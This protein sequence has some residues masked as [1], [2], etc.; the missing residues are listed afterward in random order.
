MSRGLRKVALFATFA[1]AGTAIWAAA[2]LA[3]SDAL[4]GRITAD[5]SSTVGPYVA[6]AAETFQRR[7]R[8]VR[9][10]VGISGTGGGFERFCKGE[11]D[12]VE[13]VAAA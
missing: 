9:I 13:R 4:S 12:L 2:G 5:G 7:N 1:V 10:T 8:G 3:Q 11:T 6:S